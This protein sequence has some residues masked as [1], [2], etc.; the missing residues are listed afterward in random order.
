MAPLNNEGED[1]RALRREIY[2][3]YSYF[4]FG[5]LFIVFY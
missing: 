4:A 2:D 5:G 1:S 3:A